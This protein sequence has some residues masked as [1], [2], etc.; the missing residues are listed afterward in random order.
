MKVPDNYD[1][2]EHFREVCKRDL[3]I[4]INETNVVIANAQLYTPTDGSSVGKSE[5]SDDNVKPDRLKEEE[6]P[7]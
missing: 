3:G 5:H 1:S 6:D 7:Q 4:D 2:W